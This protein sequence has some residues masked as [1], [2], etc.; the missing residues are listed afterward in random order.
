[1]D[2]Q[3]IQGKDGYFDGRFRASESGKASSLHIAH[4]RVVRRRGPQPIVGQQCVMCTLGPLPPCPIEGGLSINA[5]PATRGSAGLC[6]ASI[7]S[8]R[9]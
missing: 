6:I 8:P 3:A 4:F 7:V 9:P 5:I 2:Q 1:M